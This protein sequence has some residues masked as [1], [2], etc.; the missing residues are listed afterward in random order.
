M[1]VVFS[2]HCSLFIRS[3]TETLIQQLNSHNTQVTNISPSVKK[4]NSFYPGSGERERRGGEENVSVANNIA[5]YMQRITEKMLAAYRT[6]QSAGIF[7]DKN[8]TPVGQQMPKILL[9]NSLRKS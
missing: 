3:Q 8:H 7:D 9:E 1:M 5:N 6:Q 2:G 4:H